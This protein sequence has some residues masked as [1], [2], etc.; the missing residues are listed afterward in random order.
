MKLNKISIIFIFLSFYEILNAPNQDKDFYLFDDVEQI[1]LGLIFFNTT[2]YQ[3]YK[4]FMLNVKNIKK[5]YIYVDINF[6]PF[7]TLFISQQEKYTF[8][9]NI[10]EYDTHSKWVELEPA[11][12][13][14]L[15]I[16]VL[17]LY[18]Y[19]GYMNIASELYEINQ[20]SSLEILKGSYAMLKVKNDIKN[21]T[22][23]LVSSNKNIGILGEIL[24][25]NSLTDILFL[26][27]MTNYIY[28]YVNSTKENS[29][30]KFML[31][32]KTKLNDK[33][34]NFNN[35]NE[36]SKG[37]YAL[38]IIFSIIIFLFGGFLLYRYIKRK[39][40]ND[41]LKDENKEKNK[42]KLLQEYNSSINNS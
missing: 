26:K 3:P 2:R 21:K 12:Y 23:V 11:Q 6:S 10:L 19:R 40:Q 32:E 28:V 36:K 37:L 14:Y 29:I 42:G 8:S 1:G 13:D 7:S 15:V 18:K 33:E 27:N 4:F 41:I 34:N 38:I 24:S 31:E 35:N 17:S 5:L 25:Y 22:Y 30:I 9:K 39:K 16:Y 20:E